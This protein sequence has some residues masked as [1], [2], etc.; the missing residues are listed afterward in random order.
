[1]SRALAVA[2]AVTLVF[3]ATAA[4]R[5]DG[6]AA[7]PTTL[8][9]VRGSVDAL[10]QNGRRIAWINTRARC[11]HVQILTL[12]ARRPVDLGSRRSRNCAVGGSA[13]ALSADGRVLWKSLAEEGNTFVA[14][15]LFTATLGHAGPRLVA[16]TAFAKHDTPD[17]V[18]P[19]P[20]PMAADA[21]AILFYAQ[22]DIGDI[23]GR[24]QPAIYRLA[25]GRPKLLARITSP[26]ALAVSG[27]R[28]AVATNSLRCCNFTPAWSHDGTR[29][30]WIYHG[31]L[32]TI[33]ADGTGDRQLAAGVAPAHWPPDAVRR[34]SWSPDG[35]RLVF[36]HVDARERHSVYRVD[37]TGAGLRRLTSGTAP[38]WSP[39]GARIAFVRGTG[40]FVIKPDGTSA[41]R[42]T[43]TA[44]PTTGPLSWSPDSARIAVSRGGDI[45]SLRADGAGE[46]RL[47]SSR[48]PEAQPAWSPDGA[49][50]AYSDGS[51]IAVINADGSAVTGLTRNCDRSPAWSPDSKRI[52][53]VREATDQGA[54]W[55]VNA[56]GSDQR[57][58]IPGTGYA[59]SPQWA[60]G[61]STIAVGDWVD[62]E[63]SNWPYRPGIR[64]V[65]PANGKARKIAPVPH[66]PVELRD[67]L[68]GRLI[69]RFRINGYARAGALG[70]DYVALLV[71]HEPG[72]RVEIYGL[73][74]RFRT[75]NFAGSSVRNISAAGRAVVFATGRVIRRLDA[76]TGAV[77]TLAT[78]RRKPVGLTIEGRR[79][80]WAENGRGTARIR[81]LTAP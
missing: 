35:A 39:D 57:Q 74:G 73:N 58:L 4:A 76:R 3:G 79:V 32:W 20:L 1:V 34:P 18:D 51:M 38:A 25:G 24:R 22:C 69:K 8:A 47:T 75:A 42:L 61:G 72:V 7:R 27:R 49:R 6:Q 50:I 10:A 68:T 26:R 55:I 33:L 52:A 14:I 15:D 41:A 48:R 60:P 12:P 16:P 29:L 19:P 71:D 36:E 43:T 40:V 70:A 66:S 59:D 37:A 62:A 5:T 80:V 65:S 81:A 78:A 28:F 23:C 53:F 67:A 46:T 64:L 63:S 9:K 17:D 56:D 77:N 44:R 21:K 13:I 31:N 45:Y 2:V 11:R 54:L 30:A